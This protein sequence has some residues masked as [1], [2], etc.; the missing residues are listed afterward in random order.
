MGEQYYI[1]SRKW[2]TGDA[3]IFWR[4]N[5]KGYTRDLD[6]AGRYLKEELDIKWPIITKD[7]INEIRFADGEH[8]DNTFAIDVN[9]VELLGKRMVIIAR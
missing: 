7:N 8:H 6:E 3:H 5:R 4:E 2:T 1:W 9:D